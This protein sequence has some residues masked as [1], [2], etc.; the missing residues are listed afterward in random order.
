MSFQPGAK[1]ED[2]VYLKFVATASRCG[3][4]GP[5]VCCV[6]ASGCRGDRGGAQPAGEETTATCCCAGMGS[7]GGGDA[8][9]RAPRPGL[10]AAVAALDIGL[11]LSLGLWFGFL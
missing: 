1:S 9:P 5:R 2:D 4:G 6:A 11:W 8:P 10:A 3:G 7:A